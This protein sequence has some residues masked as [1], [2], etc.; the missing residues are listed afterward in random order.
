MDNQESVNS[1]HL[2]FPFYNETLMMKMNSS[3]KPQLA[4]DFLWQISKGLNYMHQR[5]IIHCDLSPSNI[6]IDDTSGCMFI[7]DF[8]CAHLDSGSNV[9]KSIA[10][11]EI[12]TR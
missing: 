6:L 10:H 9:E 3:K 7:C 1:Y 2:I 11:E 12:G 8:G 4:K 5:G